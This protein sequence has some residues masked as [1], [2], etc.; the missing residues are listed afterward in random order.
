MIAK[1]STNH[2]LANMAERNEK[3][4]PFSNVVP[5]A[6]IV[7]TTKRGI[8]VF[9]LLLGSVSANQIFQIVLRVNQAPRAYFDRNHL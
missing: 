4:S 5:F 8:I 3:S 6:K 7:E 9:R 2:S 1:A